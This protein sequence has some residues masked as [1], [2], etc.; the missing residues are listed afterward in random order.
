MSKKPHDMSE[1]TELHK[2]TF[3]DILNMFE[4]GKIRIESDTQILD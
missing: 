1:V 2:T 3:A 4:Q